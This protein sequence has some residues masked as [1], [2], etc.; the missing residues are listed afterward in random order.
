MF[1]PGAPAPEWDK[2]GEYTIGK[3]V[4]YAMTKNRR[5]LKVGK[6]MSLRDVFSACAGGGN[7]DAEKDG[8]EVKDG[9]VTFVV[10]PRGQVEQDWIAE[11]KSRS[12]SSTL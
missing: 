9:C 2:N 10:L 11:F 4:V 7:N 8:L 12:T 3:L 5:L 6:R 1:P